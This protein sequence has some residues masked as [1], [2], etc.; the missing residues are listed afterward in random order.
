MH[1]VI[2]VGILVVLNLL[3]DG[4]RIAHHLHAIVAVIDDPQLAADGMEG[5]GRGMRIGPEYGRPA[6]AGGPN[7]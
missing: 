5:E 1:E 3:I 2:V 7:G 6:D 4:S